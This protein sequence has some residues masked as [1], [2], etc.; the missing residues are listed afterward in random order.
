MP[1][2]GCNVFRIS[3]VD[4][5]HTLAKKNGILLLTDGMDPGGVERHVADL[6]NGLLERGYAPVIGATAGPFCSRL[7]KEVKFLDLGLVEAGSGLK[8]P[9]G[10]IRSFGTLVSEI[11]REGIVLVHSHKR[12]SDILARGVSRLTG[13]PHVS[14]CHNQFSTRKLFSLFGDTTIACS[15]AIARMLVNDFRK[16]PA[17]VRRIYYGIAP[18]A[19]LSERKKKEIRELLS[20]PPRSCVVASVGQFI[21]SKDRR[22]LV[23]AINILKGRR[24]IDQ[25]LF[26][27]LG[28]GTEK[29]EMMDLAVRLEL[30]RNVRFLGALADV[31]ALFNV[32]DFMV[33]SS[34]REGLPYVLLEAASIGK[35]HIAT[36][37]GGVA[38]F[39][40]NGKTGVLVP[41]KDPPA[42]AD[43][44]ARLLADRDEVLRLGAAARIRYDELFTMD[45]FVDE[46]VNIY[47]HHIGSAIA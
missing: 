18:F 10:F 31:E 12:Y 5:R 29:R 33:L 39:I 26:F 9:S 6:A 23:E 8:R 45:R 17:T 27:L 32:A 43:A 22:T 47:R 20:I 7:R 19:E 24:A 30:G 38:E 11:R 15:D 3:V 25:T 42:L 41:P 44:I 40:L 35:A 16:D 14:T 2:R 34:V 4:L 36:D 1:E 46:T 28:D 13:I 37:V 21:P